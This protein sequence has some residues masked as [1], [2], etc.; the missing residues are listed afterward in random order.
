MLTPR[1]FRVSDGVLFLIASIVLGG[2]LGWLLRGA[3]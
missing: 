1:L 2:V 3:W